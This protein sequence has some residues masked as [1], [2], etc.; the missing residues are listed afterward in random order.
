MNRCFWIYAALMIGLV[1]WSPI[2]TTAGQHSLGGGIHYLITVDDIDTDEF[3]DDS[4]GWLASYQFTSGFTTLELD[5]EYFPDRFA[6]FE[7]EVWAP[8]AFLVF[9][10]AL[11]AGLGIGRYYEDSNWSDPFYVLR[12]GLDLPVS[13]EWSFDINVNYQFN[14]FDQIQDVDKDVD[15]DTITLGTMIRYRF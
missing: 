14:D 12:L 1:G 7:D 4:I 3:E 2:A 13:K 5:I 8:Q 9:G 6:G 11:Y 10:S 15:T